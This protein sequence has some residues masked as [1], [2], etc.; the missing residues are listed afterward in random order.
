[1]D[2]ADRAAP[3]SAVPTPDAGVAPPAAGQSAPAA[4]VRVAPATARLT[5]AAARQPAGQLTRA[6][7]AAGRATSAA[8]A[9]S[10][11]TSAPPAASPATSARQAGDPAT[12]ARQVSRP[13]QATPRAQHRA[14]PRTAPAHPSTA[15]TAV[16]AGPPAHE[17]PVDGWGRD[18][19]A[20]LHLIQVVCWQVAGLAVL[21][22]VRQPLPVLV[23]V[24]V[25]AAVL[26]VLTT[27][28]IDGRWL[29][30]HGALAL[31]YLSRTRRRDLPE[32]AAKT[33][34][35]LDLLVPRCT[36]RAVE[37]GHGSAMTTSHR[38]GLTAVLRPAAGGTDLV[39][40]LPTPAALLPLVDGQ[41]RPLGVQTVYHAGVGRDAPVKVW[42]AVHAARSVEVPGDD[43]LA[44]ILRN[45]VR[46]MRQVLGR[47][48]VPAEPL[49][50]EAAFAVITGLAHVTG[51]RNQIREEWR[52]WRTGAVCQA[53]V[54]LRGWHRLADPQAKRLITDLLRVTVDAAA[55]VTVTARSGRDAP[56][57]DAVLRLAATTEAAVEAALAGTATRA[58]R[59]GVRP[60]RLDGA[61]AR[62]VA[63]SLPIGVFLT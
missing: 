11:A 6:R 7:P 42:L 49:T 30:E 38:S 55:T 50:E 4:P 28:R 21:L 58:A 20:H 54:Q 40:R 25:G 61:H 43:E 5:V 39:D 57:V 52:F 3:G 31:G 45:A 62:G 32:D 41:Q 63:A 15:A 19:L 27:V 8:P 2:A 17:A 12:S 24:S 10:P 22:A 51:G 16:A 37:T 53:A 1:M 48:G 44:L 23:C 56:R 26:V 47:A 14:L 46:R 59:C 34:T 35:L 36:V 60:A 33:P 13:A 9:A 18:F 29:P